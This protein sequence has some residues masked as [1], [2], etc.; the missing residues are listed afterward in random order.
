MRVSGTVKMEV[1]AKK[2]R[3]ESHDNS[4]GTLPNIS[5]RRVFLTHPSLTHNELWRAATLNGFATN[6]EL[7]ST[8]RRICNALL[9]ISKH[10]P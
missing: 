10:I 3:R 8:V 4:L 1:E 2:M 6:F 5:I 7:M 9:Q